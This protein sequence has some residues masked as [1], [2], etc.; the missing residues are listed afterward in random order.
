MCSDEERAMTGS[1]GNG[2]LRQW[3]IEQVDSGKYPGLVWENEEKSIFRIPWKHAGKQD[4]NREEDAALFKVPPESNMQF[5]RDF[6][7][8][9]L[10]KC[11][12]HLAS[13]SKLAF[14]AGLGAV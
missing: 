1:S 4:Y 10:K 12:K 14:S 3:L 8:T 13:R 2:K 6:T 9:A 11:P 5:P 7:K